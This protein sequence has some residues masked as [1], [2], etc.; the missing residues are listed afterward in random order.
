MSKKIIKII[1]LIVIMLIFFNI[2]NVTNAKYNYN[3]EIDAF[4][5][6]RDTSIPNAEITYST[7][8]PT[9]KNVTINIKVD[10]NIIPIE[11]FNWDKNNK[12][13]SK[14]LSE[15]TQEK[16]L[17][18]DY[19]GNKK[20]IEYKVDWI[21]KI[22][23]EIIG[24]ENQKT[25]E[26]PVKIDYKDNIG[27]KDIKVENYG[28]LKIKANTWSYDVE[29]KYAFDYNNTT[30]K[31]RVIQKP[32]DAVQFKYFCNDKLCAVTSN[33]EYT[34]T[35]LIPNTENIK[36]KVI[37][38]DKNDSYIE[39]EQV[40]IHTSMYQSIKLTKDEYGANIHLSGIESSEKLVECYIWEYGKKNET[41]KRYTAD[42]KN[43]IADLPFKISEFNNR[44]CRYVI[45]IYTKD[46]NQRLSN[47]HGVYVDIGK[48]YNPDLAEKPEKI[49]DPTNVRL[50]TQ[51]GRYRILV[52]DLAGNINKIIIRARNN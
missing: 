19:S 33:M 31:V 49:K 37:A 52:T 51:K 45:H 5:L 36:I 6:Y 4:K 35:N 12:V 24:V 8:E 21:D 2:I 47:A 18:E 26:L 1:F 10:K 41:E 38:V 25:Y 15:N 32:K 23:P 20:E 44:K 11:G 40:Y 50:L 3:I 48:K 14:V 30:C 16:V 7:T 34:Y 28:Y 27:I 39:S 9:N 13:L 22:K 17:L 42:V 29:E 46:A 43:G